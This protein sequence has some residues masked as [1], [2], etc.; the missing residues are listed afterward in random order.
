LESLG[1]DLDGPKL[2]LGVNT[3]VALNTSILSSILN[4]KHN[5][6]AYDCVRVAIAT[7]MIKLACIKNEENAIDTLIKPLSNEKFHDLVKEY[8][9]RVQNIQNEI[10]DYK[11]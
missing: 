6:I 9:F 10:S 5:A 2:M 4:K 1:V 8:S 11:I 7:K 3:S